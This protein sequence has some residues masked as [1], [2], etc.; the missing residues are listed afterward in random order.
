PWVFAWTQSRVNLPSWYGVGAA[1]T[2][3]IVEEEEASETDRLARLQRIYAEWPFFRSLIDNVQMGLGKGD[4]A[5]AS[6]Y[7]G[8]TDDN[9]R[10]AIFDD[11]VEEFIRTKT[12]VLQITGSKELLD[13][14]VWLQRSIRVRNPYVDPLNYIQV[15]LLE[16]LRTDPDAADKQAMREGVLLSV[17]GVAAGMQNVG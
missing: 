14:E 13:N 17:N 1:I 6:F 3:W 10:A 8:L 2:S 5:I 12:A 9:T 11:I 15:A 16:R 7:A 4:M